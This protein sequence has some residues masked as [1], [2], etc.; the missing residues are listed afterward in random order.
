MT[1]PT[2]D[3]SVTPIANSPHAATCRDNSGTFLEISAPDAP[4]PYSKL[5]GSN[6]FRVSLQPHPIAQWVNADTP[7]H[8]SFPGDLVRETP[9][10]YHGAFGASHARFLY[11][12][13]LFAGLRVPTPDDPLHD[14]AAWSIRVGR[15]DL[16]PDTDP[17]LAALATSPAVRVL[18]QSRLAGKGR[19]AVP[20][21]K[22]PPYINVYNF[23]AGRASPNTSDSY[24]HDFIV[25]LNA[26][27]T[28]ALALY[29]VVPFELHKNRARIRRAG[30]PYADN[31]L[32]HFTALLQHNATPRLPDQMHGSIAGALEA[33]EMFA[34]SRHDAGGVMPLGWNVGYTIPDAVIN[35]AKE[36]SF[37]PYAHSYRVS[38]LQTAYGD[39]NLAR[40][41][42]MNY[43]QAGGYRQGSMLRT[44][45]NIFAA[46]CPTQHF[47]KDHPC[48]IW[49][50]P[51]A[52]TAL[53]QP[54]CGHHPFTSD[55]PNK[56]NPTTEFTAKGAIHQAA[57]DILGVSVD[58]P[59][60]AR[61][62]W[63]FYYRMLL[64]FF[65]NFGRYNIVVETLPGY[66]AQDAKKI[67]EASPWAGA[68]MVHHLTFDRIIGSLFA[69]TNAL[70]EAGE[71]EIPFEPEL[72]KGLKFAKPFAFENDGHFHPDVGVTTFI[73]SEDDYAPLI[74]RVREENMLLSR[75]LSN[76]INNL[77]RVYRD[78]RKFTGFRLNEGLFKVSK[79]LAETRH[80]FLPMKVA[81]RPYVV[82]EDLPHVNGAHLPQV[83]GY[84]LKAS[85][86]VAFKTIDK[87][88]EPRLVTGDEFTYHAGEI[89]ELARAVFDGLRLPRDAAIDEETQEPIGVFEGDHFAVPRPAPITKI[90]EAPGFKSAADLA[91]LRGL[92]LLRMYSW[93]EYLNDATMT[94]NIAVT[95]GF[96]PFAHGNLAS[97][98]IVN[99]GEFV[100]Q[101]RSRRATITPPSA[102]MR[103]PVP[104]LLGD[105][106]V[107]TWLGEVNKPLLSTSTLDADIKRLST[108]Y[109]KSLKTGN[110]IATYRTPLLHA[111][112]AKD[113]IAD[114]KACA[115]LSPRLATL[116]GLLLLNEP[117]NTL[118]GCKSLSSLDRKIQDAYAQ[119]R[120]SITLKA[121]LPWNSLDVNDLDPGRVRNRKA[122][123]IDE[124]TE[125]A[126]E[127]P[128]ELA[129]YTGAIKPAPFDD[130]VPVEHMSLLG[131][132]HVIFDK[133][134]PALTSDDWAFVLRDL[135]R[136][137]VASPFTDLSQSHGLCRGDTYQFALMRVSYYMLASF[138]NYVA[139]LLR[140]KLLEEL[141][142][143]ATK[144]VARIQPLLDTA[145][146]GESKIINRELRLLKSIS[147]PSNF[148]ALE[149]TVALTLEEFKDFH[150][151]QWA[152]LQEDFN[153]AWSD[154]AA[155][156]D[157]MRYTDK[158]AI[159]G[160][161]TKEFLDR[162]ANK[163]T[164]EEIAREYDDRMVL[165][166]DS[167]DAL[168]EPLRIIQ[169]LE[170]EFWDEWSVLWATCSKTRP[171]Y[172]IYS[173]TLSAELARPIETETGYRKEHTL[174]SYIARLEP[175]L[176][177]YGEQSFDFESFVEA[178]DKVDH[179]HRFSELFGK[180]RDTCVLLAIDTDP[181][182]FDWKEPLLGSTN[183]VVVR[184]ETHGDKTEVRL[185]SNWRS[186]LDALASRS[187]LTYKRGPESIASGV[188][189]GKWLHP[190]EFVRCVL[191][192]VAVE[193]IV[194]HSIKWIGPN[195][196]TTHGWPDNDQVQG[197]PM[198]KQPAEGSM[199]TLRRAILEQMIRPLVVAGI[200]RRWEGEKKIP[201]FE[202]KANQLSP[203]SQAWWWEAAL[204]AARVYYEKIGYL[205]D[206]LE[207][208]T[209]PYKVPLGIV[210]NPMAG[211]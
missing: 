10:G 166:P 67:R 183:A 61:M 59:A 50:S 143:C 203:Y 127:V 99:D 44:E 98:P 158:Q 78:Q 191:D 5:E 60:V 40:E 89:T 173:D 19:R 76:N 202:T 86:N 104:D 12:W 26:A 192:P 56:G 205:P 46:A 160:I 85:S 210:K 100:S 69:A 156:R 155:G 93:A 75:R 22:I 16:A 147:K 8:P 148:I 115:D 17:V 39:P 6:T 11:R 187:K 94:Y 180:M 58:D 42:G 96:I 97:L 182:L 111:L 51:D 15:K 175:C 161:P 84:Y 24:T 177:A 48:P 196:L 122:K 189:R 119:K 70:I 195:I 137:S 113:A 1:S 179:G 91:R 204:E 110:N 165:I 13:G 34:Q 146:P 14:R 162:V 170:P 90:T 107:A 64:N 178:V 71:T 3:P 193:K 7:L 88:V 54:F 181:T 31:P 138:E 151:S 168:L 186:R 73:R 164:W 208:V 102:L 174:D 157:D 37:L 87:E 194:V 35:A 36:L 199:R 57:A 172:E 9:P 184:A 62:V 79:R 55:L 133:E 45:R 27:Y 20:V 140:A 201:P 82:L 114:A 135:V 124:I 21:P 25:T 144:C 150:R 169:R 185:M 41:S 209:V 108:L 130:Y 163:A 28:Q 47:M 112:L 4:L 117:H 200:E 134:I 153:Q 190:R 2:T 38:N 18:L 52:L 136:S 33:A 197:D 129:A 120:K 63:Q 188:Q 131:A 30:V 152:A 118:T 66:T 207:G 106:N 132:R 101:A 53:V 176:E 32:L 23:L 125:E 81:N 83:I 198:R 145:S 142:A 121:D 139:E 68:R 95:R 211:A 77:T 80:H 49:I 105:Y 171:L 72:A 43:S 29:G 123:M 206:G 103:T 74:G 92:T 109:E 159:R 65:Y 149:K 167:V 128:E 141:S 116:Y 126:K 154:T